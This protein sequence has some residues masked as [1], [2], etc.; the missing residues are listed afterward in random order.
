[1]TTSLF[2]ITCI[3]LA[4]CSFVSSSQEF[5]LSSKTSIIVSSKEEEFYGASGQKNRNRAL[6][7]FKYDNFECV[8][9]IPNVGPHEIKKAY[10][11]SQG[12]VIIKYILDESDEDKY[13]KKL[14]REVMNLK[15]V[16][17]NKNV[18]RFYGVTKAADHI[19]NGLVEYIHKANI[20]HRVL[21]PKYILDHD[22]TFVIIGFN[23]SVS[24]DHLSELDDLK[25]IS[26]PGDNI[27]VDPMCS[28]ADY[29]YDKSSDIY[30]LGLILWQISSGKIPHK[31]NK[32]IPVNST[33][34]DY[35]ELY[36]SAWSDDPKKR[37]SIEEIARS[38]GD[39][40]ISH[41]YQD[42]D[43]IPNVYLERNN[44]LSKKEACLFI[45]KGLYEE[46]PYLFLTQNET[47]V[48]RTES[49]HD[50][51]IKDQELG[52]QHAKIK[53]FQGKVEIFDL[54][55]KSG[56]YVN[57]KKL[58]FRASRTFRKRRFN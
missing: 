7:E 12:R 43:Y 57:D 5:K 2:L 8:E 1:M 46:T 42:S 41:V 32:E 40:D 55:S 28:N 49:N 20:V 11:E 51:I 38:L 54:G 45:N 31:K 6:K 18:M 48:G 16:D 58:E 10:I 30:S 22:G 50:I 14:H 56:I 36:E 19:S 53:S 33:P 15:D 21:C 23:Q 25:E 29:K 24:L 47:F 37:P 27:Y 35:I 52:K 13:Y 9:A 39:I 44:A 26:D 34:I 3:I 17:Q 4:F